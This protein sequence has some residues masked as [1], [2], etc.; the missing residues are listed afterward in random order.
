MAREKPPLSRTNL[1]GVLRGR[2][3][4]PPRLEIRADNGRFRN[5]KCSPQTTLASR[6]AVLLSAPLFSTEN[7]PSRSDNRRVLRFRLQ[8]SLGCDG[9]KTGS[10][11]PFPNGSQASLDWWS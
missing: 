11:A 4:R 5:P 9:E 8:S 6:D 7:F 10:L 2:L 1:G 3:G